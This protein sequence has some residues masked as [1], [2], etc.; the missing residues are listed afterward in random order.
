MS[1]TCITERGVGGT[2]DASEKWERV[3]MH[4]PIKYFISRMCETP[5]P[6]FLGLFYDKF[7]IDR[8]AIFVKNKQLFLQGQL[9]VFS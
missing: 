4:C 1:S 3:D 7:E 9:S 8:S 2:R 5:F 6:I